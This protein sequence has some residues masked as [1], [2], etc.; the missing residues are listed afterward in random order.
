MHQ[1]ETGGVLNFISKWSNVYNFQSH[2]GSIMLG[3]KPHHVT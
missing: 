3:L 1:E 2:A